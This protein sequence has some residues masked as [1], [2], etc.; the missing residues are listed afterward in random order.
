[1]SFLRSFMDWNE[2][3]EVPRNY[4]FWSG[5]SA[6]AACVNGQIYI[7]Q[8]KFVH[9]PNMYIVLLGP[10]G[11]GKTSA[12]DR[13]EEVVRAIDESISV[14]GQSETAEGLIRFMRDKCIRTMQIGN[15][16]IPYTP[17]SLY[18]SELSNFFGKDPAG[19]IDFI[20]GVWDRGGRSF[21]RRTKGQGEDMLPRPNV[22]LLS[23]TTPAWI[24]QYLKADIVGGGFTR[25]VI[26]D[27]EPRRDPNNRVSWPE[28]TPQQKA[29]RENCIAYGRVLRGL[30]GEVRYTFEAR[31]EYE[32]WYNTRPPARGEE[33][34]GYHASKPCL[35]LKTAMLLAISREPKLEVSKEDIEVALA[36]L[37]ESEANRQKVF[38]AIGRNELNAIAVKVLG[39]LESAAESKIDYNGKIHIGRFLDEKTLRSWMYR[40]GQG[41]ECEDILNHLTVT[42]RIFRFQC[43]SMTPPRMFVVLKEGWRPQEGPHQNGAKP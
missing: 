36:L 39:Y 8:G 38:T 24:T 1:M 19:M 22:N 27:N 20:T 25:R 17:I 43:L 12:I 4:F 14:S 5:V 34:E 30:F 23:G 10:A 31:M 37:S 18:L 3:T 6:I 26:F 40:D 21:H 42:E 41:R 9:Y 7:R 32:K 29:A 2:G 15:E 16:V 35:M 28:D 11:N 33:D 13:A